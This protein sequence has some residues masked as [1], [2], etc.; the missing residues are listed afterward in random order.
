MLNPI[1][2]DAVIRDDRAA[3]AYPGQI[4]AGVAWW[5]AACYV[6]VSEAAQMAVAHDGR[7]PTIEFHQRFCRGAINAEHYGCQVCDLGSADEAQLLH[8]MKVLR[9]APGALLNTTDDGGRK[10]VTIRLYA[11]DGQPV[12]EDTG[13][14]QVREKIARDRVPLPVND[15]AKGSIIDRRDLVEEP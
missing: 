13:W 11:A 10:T 7:P 6:V 4:H 1:N 14:A 9:G 5:I 8:A 2:P 3:G 15:Q 12:T